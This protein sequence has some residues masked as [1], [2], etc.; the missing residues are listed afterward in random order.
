MTRGLF[1][2]QE[3]KPILNKAYKTIYGEK[4]FFIGDRV[5]DCGDVRLVFS[6]EPNG[7]PWF[8]TD[9]EG[10]DDVFDGYPHT[11]VSEWKK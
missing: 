9:E 1:R 6:D 3:I 4:C 2:N 11:I 7:S 8:T 10:W 5:D